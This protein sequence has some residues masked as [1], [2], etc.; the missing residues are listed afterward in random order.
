MYQ[1]SL[2][3]RPLARK[4]DP[5]TSHRAAADIVPKLGDLHTW[6]LG[7]V[8]DQPGLTANVKQRQRPPRLWSA[9]GSIASR[10]SASSP[11]KRDS[12]AGSSASIWAA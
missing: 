3:D 8:R 5:Q 4:S 9:S 1:Q 12:P 6:V 10:Q 2:F 11:F 7:I